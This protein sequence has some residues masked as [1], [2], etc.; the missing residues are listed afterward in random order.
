MGVI[1]QLESPI[2]IEIVSVSLG[3]GQLESPIGFE[4]ISVSEY[5]L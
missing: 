4:I 5:P 3:E 2:G 1:G